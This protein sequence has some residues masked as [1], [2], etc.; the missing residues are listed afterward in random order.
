MLSLREGTDGTSASPSYEP[1]SP[2][3]IASM[4]SCQAL[5]GLQSDEESHLLHHFMNYSLPTLLGD[6]AHPVFKE[7]SLLLL[8]TMHVGP[9]R[10]A[11]FAISSRHLSNRKP[12]FGAQAIRYY[13]ESVHLL[14]EQVEENA[15]DG[16]DDLLIMTVVWL[17]IFEVCSSHLLCPELLTHY[18]RYG[19]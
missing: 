5:F 19:L 7:E 9:V 3:F 11:I 17:Y 4:L 6:H 16:F 2:Q 13:S 10:D 8:S 12:E 15:V 18:Y 14:R 1:R